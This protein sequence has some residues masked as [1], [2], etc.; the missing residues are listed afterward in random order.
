[1]ADGTK[2]ST[3]DKWTTDVTNKMLFTI[4]S[5]NNP[6]L[7]VS[8]WKDIIDKMNMGVPSGT[9]T[10]P[11]LKQQYGKLRK[12]FLDANP[13]MPAT[14]EDSKTTATLGPEKRARKTVDNGDDDGDEAKN[15][16][17]EGFQPKKKRKVLLTKATGKED[18][19][20]DD[21]KDDAKDEDVEVEE[22]KPK[23]KV[24]A[25]KPR[26]TKAK[27]EVKSEEQVK[28]EV[29]INDDAEMDV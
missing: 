14:G 25:R 1:M 2:D 11:A 29:A 27:K 18:G 16:D 9:Y 10:G 23:K 26:A 6:D 22:E 7:S 20:G 4:L 12:Q 8:G 24:A 17:G 21:S 28:D 15:E 19:D 13:G 3:K 5:Q